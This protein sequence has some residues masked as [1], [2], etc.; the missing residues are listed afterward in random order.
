MST[1]IDKGSH[2]FLGDKT[3]MHE[4]YNKTCSSH[5]LSKQLNTMNGNTPATSISNN[6]SHY[7][8]SVSSDEEEDYGEEETILSITISNRSVLPSQ[9]ALPVPMLLPN[10][11]RPLDEQYWGE[12]DAST[13]RIR[14]QAYIKNRAKV[15]ST[16][17]LFRLFAVDMVRTP[18]GNKPV[19]SGICSHPNERVQQCLKAEKEGKAGSEMPPFIFCVNIV[20]PGK[21]SFHVVFYYAVDNKDLIDPRAIH[22]D[23]SQPEFTKLAS[24]FFFGDSDTFRDKTFKLIPRIAKGN[25]IVKKAVGSKPALIGTK[26]KQHYIRNDRFFELII[27]VGSDKIAKKIVGLS[28]GAA[29]T[30]VVDM[31]FVL[32]GKSKDTLPEHIM[33]TVRL[34]NLDFK[35]KYRILTNTM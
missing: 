27:D 4:L 15:P 30:L 13:F 10:F 23:N 32:E 1:K 25:F 8:G 6:S 28:R 9:R 7:E 11:P 29:E 21:P 14:S 16:P 34:T 33:G 35:A 18:L 26:V 22:G 24:K 20:V 17:S 12:P 5:K 3:N 31:A 2:Q 19:L